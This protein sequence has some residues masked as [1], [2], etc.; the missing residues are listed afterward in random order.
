MG[1]WTDAGFVANSLSKYKEDLQKLFLEAF[2]E[3]FLL[4]D[5][6]PQGVL[7]TRLAELLYNTD[8]DGIEAFARL[9]PNTAT[10]IFLDL[11]GNMRGVPRGLGTPQVA[12]VTITS[13]ATNFAP[14]TIPQGHPFTLVSGEGTFVAA[15]GK[16]ISTPT[17][18]L[19]LEY[20][21]AGNSTA[22]VGGKMQT[23]GF[24]QIQDIEI[25]YLL[26]GEDRESDLEY[27][28]R[29]RASYP[30]ANNTIAYVENK[31]LETQLV[32]NVGH[33]YN[34][35]DETVDGLPR[36]T[37]EWMAVPK[38]GTDLDLF[39]DKVAT[40]IVNNKVPGSPTAGNTTVE[41]ADI[42]GTVK[43]VKFTIPTEIK[44]QIAVQV[45][46]PEAT[47]FIDL[48]AA[49]TI[50]QT[51]VDY[52][53]GL[54]IGD[55]VSYSRCLAPL[56]ADPNF[57]V[58]TFKMRELPDAPDYA[59]DQEYQNGD[60]VRYTNGVFYKANGVPE[61]A[62]TLDPAWVEYNEGWISFQNYP[63]GVRE[64]ATIEASNVSIGV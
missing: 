3:E 14:F 63:I 57:D 8:M 40:A 54:G 27:R 25:T 29:L 33:N 45:G 47:G 13:S 34:D 31:I 1:K 4:D 39:K 11:M 17:A 7:I 6:L 16:T 46:T 35:E 50:V 30:V 55:D 42:F 56:T 44:M 49:P 60:I 2:G 52:I 43:T 53:N 28:A 26:E 58:L 59:P 10:G 62:P 24:A 36:F 61:G 41:V 23:T 5:Q 32:K 15:A 22:S 37:T 9:N 12:T 48:S 19:E 38:P 51:I 18:T 64:Y 20:S 21:E